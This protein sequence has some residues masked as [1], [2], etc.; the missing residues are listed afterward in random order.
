MRS[1]R[2]VLAAAVVLVS[3]SA[4]ARAAD[5]PS[6]VAPVSVFSWTGFYLGVNSGYSFDDATRFT[7]SNGTGITATNTGIGTARPA[8]FK[9]NADGFIAGG[10]FGAN[11]QFKSGSFGGRGGVVIGF[12]AD[13]AYLDNTRTGIYDGT[14]SSVSAFRSSTGL[15]GT[16][17][18]RLGYAFDRFLLYGT[19]GVAYG[20]AFKL[21]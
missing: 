4:A 18:G 16:F 6:I 3:A 13:A 19:G 7:L 11:Y 12:E 20:N 14:A 2:G 10:Q 15:L 9:N 17:R 21:F 5:L 1:A 8:E